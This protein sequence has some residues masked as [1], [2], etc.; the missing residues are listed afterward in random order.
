MKVKIKAE[1]VWLMRLSALIITALMFVSCR[2]DHMPLEP[3]LT[4]SV[5]DVSCTEVW[6]K[7]EGIG[8]HE[9]ILERDGSEIEDYSV[10]SGNIIYDDSLQPNTTYSYRLTRLS[11]GEKGREV[12]ATTLDTTSHDIS[13]EV[14]TFGDYSSVL[15]DVSVVDNQI[16]A[17]GQI[18]FNDSTGQPDPTAYNVAYWDA[19]KW[20]IGRIFFLTFCNQTHVGAYP[21][22]SIVTLDE[23]D[24]W[25]SSGSTITRILNNEQIQIGCIPVSVNKFWGVEN[26]NI[27]AVGALGT[28]ARFDGQEWIKIES[29]TETDLLDIYG[30]DDNIFISGWDDFKGSILFNYTDGR[31]KTIIDDYSQTGN[32]PL[33]VYGGIR[34]VWVK[35]K[36]LYILT[37][38]TLFLAGT[39]AKS[40]AKVMWT[41]G[42]SEWG[43][44]RV[45]GTEVN[46]IL[47]VGDYGHLWHYNG[48]TWNIYEEL[49]NPNDIY[50]SI[51]VKDDLIVVVGERNLDGYNRYG[52]VLIGRR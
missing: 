15:R 22:K 9:F 27:Y 52:L 42:Q 6:L 14:Y 39:D 17:V 7:A 41:G 50:R 46:D 31:L 24:I 38:N 51:S 20:E 4:L 34:S 43:F 23:N 28:M 37:W 47:T 30:D 3:E 18:Y 5:A 40:K 32:N 48:S 11:G 12:T 26:N 16:W 25:V 44:N 10:I 35:R 19:V 49:F 29:N 2:T 1:R 36:H 13:W 21:A 45:R 8:S 33:Q